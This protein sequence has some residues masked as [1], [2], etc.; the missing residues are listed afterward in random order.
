MRNRGQTRPDHPVPPPEQVER[1]IRLSYAQMM[2]GAV[3]AASTGGMFLIGF[4]MSLGADN[5]VLG[6]MI[7]VPACFVV[8]QFMAAWLIQ[9]GFSR[10]KMTV[11]FS[12]VTPLCW[13][14]IASIPLLGGAMG[15][16]ARLTVL[17][18]VIAAVT[19]SGQFVGNA[20]GSWVGELIPAKRRGSFFGYCAM[21]GGIIGAV[22][23][24]IEGRFLD[25]VSSR[26]LV[27]FTALFLFGCVFGLVQAALNLPQPDCALPG[28]RDSGSFLSHVRRTVA[29]R[30][31]RRLALVHA[32]VALGGIAAPFNA[33]YCLRDVG[34]SYFGLGLL[35]AIGTAAALLT[36]P[37]WGRVVDRVGCR[38]VMLVGLLVMAPCA[39]VWLF[40]PPG[41]SLRA[42]RLL[43]WTNF[44]AGLGSAA[45]SVAIST[46][47]YKLSKPEGRAVQ[48]A[49]YSVFIVLVSAPMPLLGGWLVDGLQAAGWAV[50][51]RLTFYLWAMFV[52]AAAGL[53]RRLR[54]PGAM[55]TRTML[56]VAF[57]SR[58]DRAF[59][60]AMASLPA[61]IFW[62]QRPQIPIAE[63]ESSIPPPRTAGGG[64]DGRDETKT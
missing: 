17:I 1:A 53:A 10:K 34:L 2:L 22:F 3:F 25:F 57:P 64:A 50:D 54:E 15:R 40:I 35:N 63:G 32:V 42:Y 4:A 5:V 45:W 21:F 52:L 36:S 7:T 60:L 28:G 44:L 14:L 49:T 37:L 43:P 24:V 26:G 19:I 30:P 46:M 56:L 23:A 55:L 27:A 61:F 51:L 41:A 13:M 47:M 11:L 29:N 9:R 33:A 12:F 58:L 62:R 48:F 16:A 31:F 38:P 8:C 20:R 59:R 6:L 39:G 18:A